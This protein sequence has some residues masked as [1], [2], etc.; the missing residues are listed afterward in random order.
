MKD[1]FQ[2]LFFLGNSTGFIKYNMEFS[3]GDFFSH[4][5]FLGSYRDGTEPRKFTRQLNGLE[6]IYIL[7]LSFLDHDPD[8]QRSRIF[9]T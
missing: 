8:V 3:A 1:K 5:E 6:T 4:S 7:V 9:I 2:A